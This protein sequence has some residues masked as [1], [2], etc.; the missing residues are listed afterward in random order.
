MKVTFISISIDVMKYNV[1]NNI[2]GIK[3]EKEYFCI[4]NNFNDNAP[5][6]RL[7]Q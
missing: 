5:C 4:R 2:G 3:Y 6:C 7:Q 1:Y